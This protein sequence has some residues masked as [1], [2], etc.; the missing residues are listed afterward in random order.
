MYFIFVGQYWS[1]VMVIFKGSTT[2]FSMCNKFCV[3]III[4]LVQKGEAEGYVGKKIGLGIIAEKIDSNNVSCV[5]IAYRNYY[6][7]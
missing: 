5:F 3:L 4:I 7:T 2:V 6:I 1:Q